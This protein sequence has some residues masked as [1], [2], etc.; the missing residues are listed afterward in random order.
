MTLQELR[1][2]R[3][4]ILDVCARHGGFNVRVFGSVARGDAREDSDIDLLVELEKGRSLLDRSHL[5]LD[6]E[7]LLGRHVD[8]LSPRGIPP[9]LQDEILG[10]AIP[11]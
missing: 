9:Y 2:R 6:L 10:Q 5:I 3:K 11:L 4:E 8:A 1:T 7:A